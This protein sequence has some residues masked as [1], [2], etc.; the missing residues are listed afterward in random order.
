ME[1]SVARFAVYNLADLLDYIKS[2]LLSIPSGYIVLNSSHRGVWILIL[3]IGC[4]SAIIFYLFKSTWATYVDEANNLSVSDAQKNDEI[5]RAFQKYLK[6]WVQDNRPSHKDLCYLW[7]NSLNGCLSKSENTVPLL[8]RSMLLEPQFSVDRARYE[9]RKSGEMDETHVKFRVKFPL[10]S[11]ECEV[12]NFDSPTVEFV[13][14]V[15][16]FVAEFAV[17]VRHVGAALVELGMTVEGEPQMVLSARDPVVE[18]RL[19][20]RQLLDAFSKCEVHW[21]PSMMV[22][23]AIPRKHPAP[24]AANSPNTAPHEKSDNVAVKESPQNEYQNEQ[25]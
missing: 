18:V 4:F 10:S 6:K 22:P 23:R 3:T 15:Q 7:L 25:S 9:F 21:T 19:L 11:L 12:Q 20:E 17:I 14:S 16:D 8:L 24:Q 13:L 1:A 5:I 2:F